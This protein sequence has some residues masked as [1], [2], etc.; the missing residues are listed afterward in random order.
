MAL[1]SP[2]KTGSTWALLFVFTASNALLS[3]VSFSLWLK[4]A[5]LVAGILLPLG[6]ALRKGPA[7][8]HGVSLLSQDFLPAFPPWLLLLLAGVA[9][10]IRFYK[11]TRLFV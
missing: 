11:L 4:A 9:L 1:K 10:F 8:S 5:L 6:L 3:Y 7:A 2:V